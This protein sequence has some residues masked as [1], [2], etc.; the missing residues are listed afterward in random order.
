MFERTALVRDD[1]DLQEVLEDVCSTISELLGYRA[2]VVNVYRPAFDDMHTSA[3]VGSEESVKELVGKS[4]PREAWV[5]LLDERFARRGAYF[6]P[7]VG[8]PPAG[9][10]LVDRDDADQEPL[11]VAERHEQGVLRRPRVGVVARRDPRHVAVDSQPVPVELAGEI[12]ALVAIASHAALALRMAQDA[13][14]DVEHQRMLEGILEV[15]ARV[16]EADEAP[17]AGGLRSGGRADLPD[18]GELRCGGLRTGRKRRPHGARADAVLYQS[19]RH[20]G[21]EAVA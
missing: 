17:A 15:S 1:A 5:P 8:R 9:L 10:G 11:G 2:V 18:P 14:H 4:S 13:A 21:H 20:R 19:K 7:G 3:A 12:D 16:A 6:V